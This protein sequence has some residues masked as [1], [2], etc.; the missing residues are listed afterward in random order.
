MQQ[1]LKHFA[2]TALFALLSTLSAN[3]YDFEVDG[4]YYN[5]I[6]LPD[7]TC[8]VTFRERYIDSYFGDVVIP[9]FVSYSGRTFS[10]T[11]IGDEAFSWCGLLTSVTIPNS[12]K[13]IGDNAFRSSRLTSVT[14][15]NSVKSI[16][17]GAFSD[18]S[19]LISVTIPN[20]ITA[21]QNAVFRGCDVLTSVIIPNSV[22]RIESWAFQDCP[23]LTSII[24][25]NS[26]TSVGPEAFAECT[27]L[28]EIK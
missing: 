1:Q 19:F 17:A 18:C 12:V 24:I 7:L 5:V 25:P 6:S 16:G 8:E 3:A 28:M 27:N 26:I 22:T 13:S 15:P 10:V 9:S 11:K 2:L 4:F 20:S 23:V 21:I 14:I